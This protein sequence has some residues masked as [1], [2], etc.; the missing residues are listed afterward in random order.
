MVREKLKKVFG[1]YPVKYNDGF[2]NYSI[3]ESEHNELMF[4]DNSLTFKQRI[5]LFVLSLVSLVVI[6]QRYSKTDLFYLIPA[7]A[8]GLWFSW[9]FK[10]KQ[11]V[12]TNEKLVVRQ[13]SMLVFRKENT[14]FSN[15]IIK[16]DSTP[17]EYS[18]SNTYIASITI[19]LKSGKKRN[20]LSINS[21]NKEASI[22]LSETL[23]SIYNHKLGLLEI[24]QE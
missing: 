11:I 23:A 5:P 18:I 16:I 14:Y 17:I 15:E 3:S 22:K 24:N 8:I 2:S 1:E 21:A 4:E 19:K 10:P 6:Y 7:F 20:L 9:Q 13:R 12:A